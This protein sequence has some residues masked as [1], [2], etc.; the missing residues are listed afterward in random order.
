MVSSKRC[1]DSTLPR[2]F[3]LSKQGDSSYGPEAR[4]RAYGRQA[5]ET[6][7]TDNGL[8]WVAQ[9]C[10]LIDDAPSCV[11]LITRIVKECSDS[12]AV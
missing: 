3:R 11:D 12:I 8:L 6:G 7:E 4:S 10:G 2:R 5:L 1:K 9:V